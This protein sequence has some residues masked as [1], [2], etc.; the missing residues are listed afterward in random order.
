MYSKTKVRNL[1][2]VF[3]CYRKFD[4]TISLMEMSAKTTNYLLNHAAVFPLT[5]QYF[6]PGGKKWTFCS[7]VTLEW[8]C[9]HGRV[10]S[11]IHDRWDA[12]QGWNKR[13]TTVDMNIF[14]SAVYNYQVQQVEQHNLMPCC[15]DL[16]PPDYQF[17]KLENWK[18]QTPYH[19]SSSLVPETK[20]SLPMTMLSLTPE[21]EKKKKVT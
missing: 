7:P 14:N 9:T 21:K 15:L 4:S 3:S 16:L 17:N 10:W 13:T 18:Q 20:G 6:Q 1:C 8:T 11:R 19:F 2:S 5:S 12:Q